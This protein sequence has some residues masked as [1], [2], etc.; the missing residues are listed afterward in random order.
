[1]TDIT[2]TRQHD[3]SVV[4]FLQRHVEFQNRVKELEAENMLLVS[5]LD[6]AHEKIAQQDRIIRRTAESRDVF[7]SRCVAM[8]TEISGIS[9][10]CL[11]ALQMSK[12]T[13]W[14]DNGGE[15]GLRRIPR[16]PQL[17]SNEVKT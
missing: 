14:R 2:T 11:R 7:K 8:E 16:V 12:Q 5:E 13:D 17:P 3:P 6:K 4:D 1:M 10:L 9:T 15:D